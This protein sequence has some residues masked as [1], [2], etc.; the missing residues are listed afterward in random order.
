[1]TKWILSVS[2]SKTSANQDTSADIPECL[3]AFAAVAQGTALVAATGAGGYTLALRLVKLL[4]KGQFFPGM[5][6]F[7]WTWNK[8]CGCYP[9]LDSWGFSTDLN[10]F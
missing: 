9:K 7:G 8:L 10:M 3:E 2:C 5:V 1:M 4:E 6:V